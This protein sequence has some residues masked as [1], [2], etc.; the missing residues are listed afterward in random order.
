MSTA[1]SIP[2]YPSRLFSLE[3]IDCTDSGEQIIARKIRGVLLIERSDWIDYISTQAT[4]DRMVSDGRLTPYHENGQ[5][6]ERVNGRYPNNRTFYNLNEYLSL[7]M[8][9]D[10]K[11]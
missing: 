3:K 10:H 7:N 6:K 5:P 9:A 8:N 11:R 2:I 4:T 1:R